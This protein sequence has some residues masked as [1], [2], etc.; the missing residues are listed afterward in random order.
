MNR[1][2]V[3]KPDLKNRLNYTEFVPSVS[4][5]Y[6][7]FSTSNLHQRQTRLTFSVCGHKI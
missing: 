4:N 1:K 3:E 2:N 5:S 6:V 7:N